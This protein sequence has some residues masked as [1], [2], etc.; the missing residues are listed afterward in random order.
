MTNLQLA[1]G[2]TL[3]YVVAGPAGGTPLVFHGGTPSAALLFEPVVAAAARHGLQTVTY[4]RAGY[5]GSS[6]RPGRI[7]A[8][9]V[10]DVT[11]LLDALS[12]DRFLTVGWSGG[13]PHAL[14]CAA[15]LPGRCLAAATIAGV[16]P[17]SAEGL[18]WL[19]GM[20]A[21]NVEEFGAALAGEE[22]LTEFLNAAAPAVAEVRADQ[23]A[24][25]LGDLASDVDREA[26]TDE[27]AEYMAAL[28]RAAVSA[29]IAGWRDDDLAFVRD[30]G[31]DVGAI[32]TPVA[33][34]QGTEDRM[35]PFAHGRWLAS[36][37]PGASVHL[38]PAEGH[39]SLVLTAF[40]D[41]VTELTTHLP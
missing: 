7:V 11:A 19:G 38:L 21:E 4:S 40:D 25:S 8:D 16:A 41:I 39:L 15:L 10:S 23:V 29:G 2:R 1:D 30:W 32:E 17:R 20:G 37:L 26:L 27:F 34:W 22:P 33:I 24:A 12:L 31:F 36:R 5:A 35:V 9:V 6:P 13:G 3:Q 18:D 28:F 14:A